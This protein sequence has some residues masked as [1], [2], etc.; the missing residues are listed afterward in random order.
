MNAIKSLT[1]LT[2]ECHRLG[3]KFIS[4]PAG[5]VT[6]PLFT[7]SSKTKVAGVKTQDGTLFAKTVIL[8]CGA[9]LPTMLDTEGQIVAK[10]WC[11]AHLQLTT[12]EAAVFKDAPVINN[13]E[14]GY[15]FEPQDGRLKIAPQLP[16]V[17]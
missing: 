16:G 11:L 14:L 10:A 3:V 13:R 17:G 1:A 8:A 2:N 7:D 15:F 4:G 12:D 9:W 6:A 5:T